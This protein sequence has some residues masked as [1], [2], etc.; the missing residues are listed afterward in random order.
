M[1]EC[2]KYLQVDRTPVTLADGSNHVR[3]SHSKGQALVGPDNDLKYT[4]PRELDQIQIL[5]RVMDHILA[6][7]QN[8]DFCQQWHLSLHK[9]T[10]KITSGN[11]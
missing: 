6:I 5:S 3:V 8:A 9:M 10:Q 2:S 7:Q 4:D 1:C 11:M